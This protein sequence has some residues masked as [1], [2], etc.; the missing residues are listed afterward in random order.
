MKNQ[1]Q[2][3]LILLLLASGGCSSSIEGYYA[4]G[5]D[6]VIVSDTSLSINV[7]INGDFVSNYC[8]IQSVT[9]SDNGNSRIVSGEIDYSGGSGTALGVTV[10]PGQ[11]KHWTKPFTATI[12]LKEGVLTFNGTLILDSLTMRNW[13]AQYKKTHR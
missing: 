3:C 1:L 6:Y 4:N 5:S 7:K 8:K 11:E 13:N 12:D 10:R 2:F 9:T